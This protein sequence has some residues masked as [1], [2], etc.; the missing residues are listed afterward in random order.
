MNFRKYYFMLVFL[1]VCVCLFSPLIGDAS[2]SGDSTSQSLKNFLS[3]GGVPI[4][5]VRAVYKCVTVGGTM[6]TCQLI[7]RPGDALGPGE[8][9]TFTDCINN[10]KQC[11]TVYVCSLNG[12]LYSD[13]NQCNETCAQVAGCS[14]AGLAASGGGDISIYERSVNFRGVNNN[15]NILNSSFSI[16]F[17]TISNFCTYV[18]SF[19]D[20][21]GPNRCLSNCFYYRPTLMISSSNN[22]ITL[23]VFPDTGTGGWYDSVGQEVNYHYISG[24]SGVTYQGNGMWSGFHSTYLQRS[25]CCRCGTSCSF[26]PVVTYSA[27]IYGSGNQLCLSNGSQTQCVTTSYVYTCPI[28]SSLACTGSPPTCRRNYSCSTGYVCSLNNNYFPTLAQCQTYCR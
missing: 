19:I 3:P 22:V 9:T 23:R 11:V 27:T 8:Y 16:S 6:T 15:I 26:P 1:S 7:E 13:A 25:H 28:D 21:F 12:R 5:A 2:T 18:E 20:D 10:C 17:T 4:E 24:G 14:I